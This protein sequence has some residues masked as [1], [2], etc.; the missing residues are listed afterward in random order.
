MKQKIPSYFIL[1]ILFTSIIIFGMMSAS[2]STFIFL[3][4]APDQLLSWTLSDINQ[5]DLK[6][7]K[8]T[9]DEHAKSHKDGK[10]ID[11]QIKKKIDSI[12][13]NQSDNFDISKND[14]KLNDLVFKLAFAGFIL[15]YLFNLPFKL[16][17]SYKRKN[18]KTPLFIEKF[19]RTFLLKTP[20]INLLIFMSIFIVT[21]LV[22]LIGM[23]IL[24]Y[25]E[26]LM[27]LTRFSL[28]LTFTICI[29]SGLLIFFWQKNRVQQKYIEHFYSKDELKKR[30]DVNRFS[31]LKYKIVISTFMTTLLPITVV[32][33]YVF[34]S[35][36]FIENYSLLKSDEINLLFGSFAKLTNK[37]Y[38]DYSI[39]DFFKNMQLDPKIPLVFYINTFDSYQMIIGIISGLI[40]TIFYVSLFVRWTTMG[41]VCSINDVLDNMKEIST[42]NFNNFS[43]VRT[44]DEVGQL[45]EGVNT[46]IVGLQERE[47]LKN[48]FGRY[49]AKEISE[50]ILKGNVN[51]GGD[52][53]NATVMFT[54]IR[55]FTG[56]AQNISPEEVVLFLNSYLN[57]MIEVILK[58]NGIIDKFIGDGIL[59][60]FGVPVRTENHAQNAVLASLAMREALA[61][62][63]SERL[64]EGK[65]PVEIGIGL[66]S[67]SVIAGNIGNDKK[68][69]FTVIGDTVNLASR[70]EKM[71]KD[72]QKGILISETTYSL[73]NK[74]WL[75]TINSKE[76]Q[77]ISI[78]GK[79]DSMILYSF[80]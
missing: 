76:H 45:V 13:K 44:N 32:I 62:F 59:A 65:F 4:K 22:T 78:R 74:E 64:A 29:L 15:Y 47:N 34:F 24:N 73:L 53:Y 2:V 71:T 31:S 46:M 75:E 41:I 7:L 14:K 10:K 19:C 58:H 56:I 1:R 30:L 77:N 37:F 51:L 66:H 35:F 3:K 36:T 9:F 48:L 11:D 79:T 28:L 80:E 67:G 6:D 17:L 70:I 12:I 18:K 25:P 69:E 38:S 49:L 27:K 40:I 21:H 52:L 63:N 5:Q 43:I 61:R 72:L 50:E 16:F 42:G 26:F 54:D 23:N 55:N 57:H 20:I 68:M 33:F 8:D 60:I 39:I